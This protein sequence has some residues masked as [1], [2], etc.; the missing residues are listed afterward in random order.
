M[1]LFFEAYGEDLRKH[2]RDAIVNR[3]DRLGT[4][5][6]GN[7]RKSFDTFDSV[8]D[9]Y[10][11]KWNGPKHFEWKDVSIDVISKTSALVTAL[12]EW[13]PDSGD[14]AKCSYTGLFLKGS[15]EWRIRAEDE[16]CVPRRP[17]DSK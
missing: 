5:F 1:R 4:Y 9:R 13:T 12:F 14:V 3:Y 16:S 11:K 17:A 8:K 6:M 7:G 10:L 15:G 2:R